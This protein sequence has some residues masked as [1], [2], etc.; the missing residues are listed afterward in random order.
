MSR[1]E[2]GGRRWQVWPG[3]AHNQ[4][5]L[6][7]ERERTDYPPPPT[8][9]EN[10]ATAGQLPDVGRQN[11]PEVQVEVEVELKEKEKAAAPANRR[12]VGFS[13]VH[14]EHADERVAAYL[15][16][17]GQKQI[18][19]TNAALILERIAP[20]TCDIWREVLTAW[21]V[22]GE[23]GPYKPSNFSGMFDRYDSARN[24]RRFPKASQ[25]GNGKHAMPD[26]IDGAREI[27]RQ[28]AAAR[29]E[30]A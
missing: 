24:A 14:T 26:I 3:F 11:T 27:L 30:T 2:S 10:P 1:F 13:S 20:G 5:N 25:N 23:L 22:G 12:A 29:G 28:R 21:A 19:E 8:A 9:R 16:I 6:R 15:D 4:P 18:T 7:G 17:L